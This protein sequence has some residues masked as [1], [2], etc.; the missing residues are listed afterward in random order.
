[1]WKELKGKRGV[2]TATSSMILRMMK[3]C[4]SFSSRL[5]KAMIL[6]LMDLT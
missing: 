1:M 2:M 4:Y 6:F 3:K 5:G